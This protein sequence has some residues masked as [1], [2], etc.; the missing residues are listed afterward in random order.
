VT[1]LVTGATSGIGAAFARRLAAEGADLVLV[2]RDID[3]LEGT[4][5]TLRATY[6]IGVE[7]LSADLAV[8]SA[9]GPV[10]ARLASADRPVDLLVNNA[11]IGM[12]GKFWETPLA[13]QER[14]FH[15]NCTAV[16]RLSHAALGAMVPRGRGDI[17]VVS[18]VS[19]FAPAVRGAYGASKAYA[20][21]FAESLSGQLAGT[22]VHVSAVAPG[23][24]RTEFHGRAGL[25][26]SR[27]PGFMWLDADRVAETALRD[28]RA[29]KVLSVPG[30]QYKVIVAASRLIPPAV[31]RRITET[32]RRRTL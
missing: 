16:L 26:M 3:R 27:Q 20:T 14:M 15:L 30:A 19:G 17:V 32:F 9:T 29:G 10:L 21:A 24:V 5:A 28:H 7:V 25:D 12:R 2:A 23:F 13:D 8:E 6:G 22:G 31:N 18:S 4:A 11:G 1:A